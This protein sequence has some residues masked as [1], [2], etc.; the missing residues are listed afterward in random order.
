[1]LVTLREFG[2]V[3]PCQVKLAEILEVVDDELQGRHLV[4][5][6][7]KSQIQLCEWQLPEACQKSKT[8][9]PFLA[10]ARRIR[11]VVRNDIDLNFVCRDWWVQSSAN[12]QPGRLLGADIAA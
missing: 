10:A 3:P 2:D 12:P 4:Q 9:M 11:A 6:V 8:S 7:A 5:L 1:M